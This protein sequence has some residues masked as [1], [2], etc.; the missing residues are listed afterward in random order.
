LKIAPLSEVNAQF[1]RYIEESARGPIIVTKNGRPVAV[2]VGAPD[3]ED[4]ER[5]V[6]AYTPRFRRLLDAAEERI[7]RTGGMK[8]HDF[9]EDV[10]A[11][12]PAQESPSEERSSLAAKRH[13][14][15]GTVGD[16]ERSLFERCHKHA[17]TT[18]RADAEG[19]LST[20]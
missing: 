17:G 6:L 4:L 5:L 19:T 18:R 20:A 3:E 8:H 9:W 16:D 15:G 12:E 11:D 2:I 1:S 10:S 13:R 7:R 14:D